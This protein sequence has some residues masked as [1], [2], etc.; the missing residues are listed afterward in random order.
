MS[1]DFFTEGKWNEHNELMGVNLNWR[2]LILLEMDVFR[3]KV[4]L[5]ILFRFSGAGYH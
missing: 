1:D 5:L 3:V 4:G 2:G